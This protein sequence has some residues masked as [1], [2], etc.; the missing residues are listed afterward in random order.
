[1]VE[2][3]WRCAGHGGM[4]VRHGFLILP[5][6]YLPAAP[7]ADHDVAETSII[8]PGNSRG[9]GAAGG[10][11]T[12]SGSV[13]GGATRGSGAAAKHAFDTMSDASGELADMRIFAGGLGTGSAN[14]P[15]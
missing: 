11:T 10:I 4:R 2:Y 3:L 15:P 6:S 8:A 7:A 1:M 14:E 13:R 12:A 9:G 5:S